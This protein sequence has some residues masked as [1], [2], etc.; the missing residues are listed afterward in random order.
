MIFLTLSCGCP[1]KEHL[2]FL[3]GCLQYGNNWKKVEAYEKTRTSTQIRFLLF[4]LFQL[5]A[6]HHQN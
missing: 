4:S 2:M 5:L 1:Q 3:G 6:L